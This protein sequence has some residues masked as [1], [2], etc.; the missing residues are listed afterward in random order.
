MI[1][2]VGTDICALERLARMHERHGERLARRI[3][4][5]AEQGDYER[6]TARERLLAKRFAAK[7]AFSKAL[8]T[9][10]RDPVGLRSLAVTHDLQGKPA[11]AYAPALAALMRERGLRAHLSISDERDYALAFVVIEREEG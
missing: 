9:G 6:S 3:L 10:L 2:G 7:E 4:A 5:P 8:G 11:F 1:H